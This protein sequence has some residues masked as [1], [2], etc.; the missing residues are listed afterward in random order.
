MIH[1]DTQFDPDLASRKEAPSGDSCDLSNLSHNSLST[2]LLSDTKDLIPGPNTNRLCP[3][4]KLA[5]SPKDP[6]FLLM[7]NGIYKTN[8]E[9]VV[10]L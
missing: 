7:G 10:C 2:S 5:I 3:A 9:C 6:S 8:S 1:F 4:L